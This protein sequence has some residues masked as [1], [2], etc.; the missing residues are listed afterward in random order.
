MDARPGEIGRGD[1]QRRHQHRGDHVER[2]LR[3]PLRQVGDVVEHRGVNTQALAAENERDEDA[4]G[5]N[6]QQALEELGTEP[7]N[8][9]MRNKY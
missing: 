4:D 9:K 5:G 1:D 7:R 3:R 6:L 2:E 8:P